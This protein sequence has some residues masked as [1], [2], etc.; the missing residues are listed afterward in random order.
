MKHKHFLIVNVMHDDEYL[1]SDIS[2]VDCCLFPSSVEGCG[3]H[4]WTGQ[5][6]NIKIGIFSSLLISQHLGV[7]AKTGHPRVRKICD[8]GKVASVLRTVAFIRLK[9]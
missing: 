9:H 5:T 3:F 4:P 1:C 7:R 8:I 6:K 2:F